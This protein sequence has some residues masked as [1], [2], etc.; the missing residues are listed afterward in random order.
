[1]HGLTFSAFAFIFVLIVMA[2]LTQRVVLRKTGSATYRYRARALMSKREAQLHARLRFALPQADIYPQVAMSALVDAV[3]GGTAARNRFDRKVFDFALFSRLGE[4]L[5]VIELDDKSHH[6]AAARRRDAVKNEICQAA[7]I[8]LVRYDSIKVDQTIL[9][10]DFERALL[11]RNQAGATEAPGA[12]G[13][14]GHGA[15]SGHAAAS[16]RPGFCAEP[17][18]L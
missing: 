2:I 13:T 16:T 9:R 15:A 7:G 3:G 8:V 4:L 12:T 10:A 5:Y 14:L 17:A 11:A 6:A 18:A 1:M